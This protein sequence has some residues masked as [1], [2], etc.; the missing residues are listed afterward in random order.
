MS[1]HQ[2]AYLPWLGFFHKILISDTF[3]ILDEVQFE[4]SSFINRNKIKAANGPQWITVPL[5]KSGYTSKG[6]LEME[7]NNNDD[8]ERKHWLY[9]YSNYKNAPFFNRYAEFFQS[10]YNQKWV[11]LIDLIMYTLDFF[12]KEMNINTQII[13]QSELHTSEKK[14]KLIIE[15]CSKLHQDKF[16][17]GTFGKNYVDEK[18][19]KDNGIEIYF[20]DYHYP[21]YN[22]QWGKFEPYMSIVDLLFNVGSEKAGEIIMKD[23]ISKKELE[24]FFNR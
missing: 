9:L 5:F 12:V 11:Y 15:M 19:F 7:I 6:I 14:E 3:V 21:T 16:V 13:R 1:G 2:P 8:W 10:V 22:Q 20:Q 4:K 18:L 17:F 24:T 23:N